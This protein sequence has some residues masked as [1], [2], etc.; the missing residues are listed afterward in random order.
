MNILE[1][2]KHNYDKFTQSEKSIADYIL[3]IEDESIVDMSSKDMGV[4]TNTSAATVV[5]FA[6]KLGVNSFNEL[7]FKISMALKEGDNTVEFEYL[8]KELTTKDII[9][10]IKNSMNTV[11]DRTV[12]LVNAE[13]LENAIKLLIDAKNIYI[14]SV[15][16]SAIVAQDFYYKLSRLNKRVVAH[17][18]THLQIASSAILEDGDVALAISYSGETK[19]ILKCA[20]N[21]KALDIPVIAITKASIDNN[22]ANLATVTIPIP[23]VEKSLREGAMSSR[24]SQLAI[25]DMLFIGIARHNINEM[26]EK[27]I[28]TRKAIKS[29]NNDETTRV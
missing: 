5:R 17:I 10:V 24:I 28:K 21:A 15:G 29:F 7:K 20:E 9:S 1:Y 27:L 18:D 13:D 22:L 19:E 3:S 14:Y 6:Q 23:Y 11:I 2:I 16:G 8:D 12:E 4:I 26:E 25:I